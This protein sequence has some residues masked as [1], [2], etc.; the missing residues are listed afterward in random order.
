M[1]AGITAAHNVVRASVSPAP[2]SPLVAL[3]W[4][5]TIA[6]AAQTWA[7]GCNWSHSSNAYGENIYAVSGDTVTGQAVVDDW[8]SESVDYDYATN[9]CS[10]VC[11][12]YTQVVWADT[13]QVGC[14][15]KVCTTNS[16]FPAKYGPTWTFV[17]C[18]YD[19]PGNVGNQSPY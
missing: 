17:V 13:T 2:S 4:S 12:H 18:D 10:N 9:S 5:D 1:L 3:T 11:G 8:A 7:N 15:V 16:P 6:S 14:G 19:P